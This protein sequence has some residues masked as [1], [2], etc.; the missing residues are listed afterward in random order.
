MGSPL[1]NHG[2]SAC[3]HL[4]F[5]AACS[6]MCACR[7]VACALWAQMV[8]AEQFAEES[9]DELRRQKREELIKMRKAAEFE[10][11]MQDAAKVNTAEPS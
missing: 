6:Y 3:F 8:E 7:P 10:A 1:P 9:I 2:A 4:A 5:V 11:K